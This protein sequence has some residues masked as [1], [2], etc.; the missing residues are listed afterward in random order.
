MAS[1]VLSV[2]PTVIMSIDSRYSSA[3]NKTEIHISIRIKNTYKSPMQQW[4]I[5]LN[6][7]NPILK[8]FGNDS[9]VYDIF[10]FK[11]TP[12]KI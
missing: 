10:T 11:V 4:N 9:T 1:M 6:I 5:L 8:G 7:W 2:S 12:I 3:G